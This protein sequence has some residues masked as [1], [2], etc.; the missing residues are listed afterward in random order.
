MHLFGGSSGALVHQTE[1]VPESST[2]GTLGYHAE[3]DLV[4]D[5]DHGFGSRAR[6]PHETL[7][8]VQNPAL[9]FIEHPRRD[10]KGEGVEEN[11]G[12][13]VC[14]FEDRIQAPASEL[15]EPPI[16]MAPLAV[17]FDASRE[18]RVVGTSN[19]GSDIEDVPTAQR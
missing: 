16:V 11:N 4:A 14:G 13:P 17:G 19:G 10:P 6:M 8:L 7:E 9:V 5:Q 3:S 2:F 18:I 1:E 15:Q 12:P